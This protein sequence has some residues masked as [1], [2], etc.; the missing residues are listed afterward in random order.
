MTNLLDRMKKLGSEANILR[1]FKTLGAT[2]AGSSA[3][4]LGTAALKNYL[5]K[6]TPQ[7]TPIGELF[8]D[9]TLGD[10]KKAIPKAHIVNIPSFPRTSSEYASMLFGDEPS[11]Q[12]SI[13]ELVSSP[14][15]Y[16]SS[17][18]QGRSIMPDEIAE[19]Y[20]DLSTSLKQELTGMTPPDKYDVLPDKLKGIPALGDDA[21]EMLTKGKMR[22]F[23]D[24]K[25]TPEFDKAFYK[26]L[27][28]EKL[29]DVVTVPRNNLHSIAHELGHAVG[30]NEMGAAV[31]AKK[32][33][34]KIWEALSEP[35]STSLS[36]TSVL[37][38]LRSF[39]PKERG[40]LREMLDS[41]LTGNA[42]PVL[43]MAPLVGSDTL[44]GMLKSVSPSETLDSGLDWIG[45]NPISTVG[46]AGAP[47]FINE[48]FT[49]APGGEAT[50]NFF[51]KLKSR[52]PDIAAHPYGSKV[53]S[54]LKNISPNKEV[55]KF[56]GHNVG[57]AAAGVSLPLALAAYEYL[58]NED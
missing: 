41:A 11:I 46:I 38:K 21:I 50:Y 34:L 53:L 29:T 4:D 45:D 24:L 49:T 54:K 22:S 3:I 55:L 20:E 37:E 43:A 48:A 30:A 51:N 28:L 25:F 1:D 52:A 57:L 18:P 17:V 58:T 27:D 6:I 23:T 31:G 15:A 36:G 32:I 5:N 12:R 8:F 14:P 16:L 9:T 10:I 7:D 44:R 47:F 40:F 26:Y 56:L 19:V 2:G 35:I 39:L 42:L 13:A 33:P